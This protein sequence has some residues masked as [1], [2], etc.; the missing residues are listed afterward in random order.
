MSFITKLS[1]LSFLVLA[2]SFFSTNNVTA[3]T[4]DSDVTI[5]EL[6]QTPGEIG[7]QELKLKPGKYQFRVVNDNVDHEVGFVIQNAKDAD[8]DVMETALPNSFASKTI[9][10]GEFAYTG[11]VNLTKGKYVYSCP[12][13]PTPHYSI[14]VK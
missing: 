9:N 14:K 5:I 13:N 11:V 4:T 2:I 12:L 3:Q 10:A 7:T 1:T 8:G 6:H